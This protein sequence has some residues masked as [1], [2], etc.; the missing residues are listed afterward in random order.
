MALQQAIA[1][2][3]LDEI[4]HHFNTEKPIF[5]DENVSK[6]KSYFIDR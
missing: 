3:H 6:I 5:F 1:S 4:A 2:Q